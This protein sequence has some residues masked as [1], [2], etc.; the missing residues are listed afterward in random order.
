MY[1][2]VIKQI[3]WFNLDL[4]IGISVYPCRFF[5]ERYCDRFFHIQ[6]NSIIKFL[7]DRCRWSFFFMGESEKPHFMDWFLTQPNYGKLL[8]SRCV[9][10][11][12]KKKLKHASPS[13]A[14]TLRLISYGL[15]F[16]AFKYLIKDLR[17]IVEHSLWFATIATSIKT[18]FFVK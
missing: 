17:L 3:I 9:N 10:A 16:S 1:M 13:P 14:T 18:N 8:F 6:K 15:H 12:L 4:I 5:K 2:E 11:L 7:Y